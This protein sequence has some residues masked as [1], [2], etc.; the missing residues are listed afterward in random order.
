MRKL[1]ADYIMEIS[2][3]IRGKLFYPLVLRFET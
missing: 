2:P 3:I 1:Q